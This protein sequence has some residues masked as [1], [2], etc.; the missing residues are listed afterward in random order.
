MDSAT[1]AVL[2]WTLKVLLGV[3]ILIY[4]G[5][6]AMT[7]A[8]DGARYRPRLDLD[9]PLRSLQRLLVWLG[10][11][12]VEG[13]RRMLRATLN[14]FSEASAEVGEWFVSRRSRKEQQRFHSHVW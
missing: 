6:V 10:V 8:T 2:A 1:A 14:V 3:V 7:Y 13:V 9:A 12:A 11:E 4:A 5:L